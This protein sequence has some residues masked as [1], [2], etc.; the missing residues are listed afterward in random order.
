MSN[1]SSDQLKRTVEIEHGGMATFVCSVPVFETFR[2]KADWNGA[3]QVFDLT[4][5][6]SGAA[7][8]YAWSC[9]LADGQRQSFA[10]LHEG[11]VAS[12]RDAVRAVVLPVEGKLRA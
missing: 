11:T 3:V 7:R 8:A 6:P 4:A 5:S 2:G 9:G 12:A 1:L 10:I